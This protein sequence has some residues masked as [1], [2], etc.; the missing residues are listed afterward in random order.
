MTESKSTTDS[1]D[2]PKPSEAEKAA[3]QIG[4]TKMNFMR[5]WITAF[6]NYASLNQ[7]QMPSNFEQARA[8]LPPEFNYTLDPNSFEMVYHGS[9]SQVR[10]KGLDPV[11]IIV[12]REGLPTI[13]P[14]GKPYKAYGFADG[15]CEIR[16]EPVEG[17][18]N[19]EKSRILTAQ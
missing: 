9:L 2:E 3:K 15:H 6:K 10:E 5:D 14:N 11:Q 18:E 17:F 7:G 1:T 13:S 16:A 19:W 8:Y 12:L 4:L